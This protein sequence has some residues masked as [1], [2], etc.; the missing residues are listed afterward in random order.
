MSIAYWATF[1]GKVW[2]AV[3]SYANEY[4]SR[5]VHPVTVAHQ[6]RVSVLPVVETISGGKLTVA[7]V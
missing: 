1:C 2:A 4:S 5:T 3:Q 7:C 6:T